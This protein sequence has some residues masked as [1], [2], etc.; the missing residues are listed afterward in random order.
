MYLRSIH[1]RDWKAYTDATLEFAP[2]KRGKNVV[3]IGAKNGYGKTTLLE[4]LVLGLF[5]RHGLDIIGRANVGDPGEA[6]RELSYNEFMERALHA[7][8]K[9]QGRSSTSITLV[10]ED[11]DRERIKIR[12]TWH[13]TGAGKHR[14]DQEDVQVFEGQDEELLRIPRLDDPQEFI[15]SYV[16]QHF[17]NV[18]LAQFFLF[19][20]EQVQRLAKRDMKTQVQLGIEGILGVPILRELAQD[21]RSYAGQ[22]RRKV[23]PVGDEKVDRLQAEINELEVRDAAARAEL[24]LI[25]P[26]LGPLKGEQD[27]IFKSMSSLNDGTYANLKEIYETK[28]NF[29]K[30]CD[31][32][33]E[34]LRKLLAED[35]ALALAGAT[36]RKR[37]AERI[38]AESAREKWETGKNQGDKGFTRFVESFDTMSPELDPPLTRD[39]KLQLQE[40]LKNAWHKIWFPPPENCAPDYRHPYLTESTRGLVIAKLQSVDDVAISQ[41]SQLLDQIGEFE[42]E[43][44]KLS[45]RIAQQSGVENEAERL[46]KKLE[47]ITKELSELESRKRELDRDLESIKNLL[48]PKRQEF[49]RYQATFSQAEPQLRRSAK[50]DRIADMIDNIIE[51]SFPSHISDVAKSM[52]ACYLQ[53]AHK[54]V[55]KRIAIDNDCTVR[56]LGANDRDLRDMDASA[57]ESQIFALALIAAISKVSARGFPIVMDTP[58]ARLDPEHRRAVL[59]YFTEGENQIILLSQPAEITG[60]YY[61]LVAPRI[62]TAMR[63]EHEEIADGVGRSR[64]VPGYYDEGKS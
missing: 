31:R 42:T 50:A 13:F 20:G 23:G 37:T 43:I 56:L 47:G 8:A 34:Q 61:D 22:A 6:Q 60:E 54:K 29:T 10:F 26:R 58:L 48:N 51:D 40:R 24:D 64:I 17:L 9:S 5:G 19:D 38:A 15:R 36:M 18:S 55:V 32:S 57:G 3:L 46:A 4:G 21:L 53:M 30:N 59:K 14:P 45:N 44:G 1:F 25:T 62:A 27:S 33:R 41:I 12:R 11:R 16:T 39:Q 52:T 49:G 2:P 7:Q 63:I 28:E 35:V